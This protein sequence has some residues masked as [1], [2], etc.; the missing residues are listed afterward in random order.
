M[1][2]SETTRPSSRWKAFIRFPLTRIFLA[3]LIVGIPFILV[4]RV[5][6]LLPLGHTA[7]N[8]LKA[9]VCI[10]VACGM[11]R[12]AVRVLERRDATEFALKSAPVELGRG[13][14]TGALLF[15][16][17][18]G[19]LAVLGVYRVTGT[20]PWSSVIIPFAVA[21][22]IGTAE[23]IVF[24]GIIFRITEESLGTWIALLIS[25]MIFGLLHLIGPNST[26]LGA[27]SIVVGPSLLL[28]GAYKATG[29]LWFP[30]G[31]HVAWNFTQEG[32][33]G[34]M[35]SGHPAKGLLLGTLSGPEWLSG[36]TFGAE[37]SV[38]ATLLCF[39]A[40]LILFA[41]AI[42]K[43]CIVPPSWKRRQEA[44]PAPCLA[45]R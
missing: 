30:I 21:S 8:V 14:A 41:Q 15:A 16:A 1:N 32:I 34:V 39:F 2:P 31:L 3:G 13:L 22:V 6:P 44:D 4:Q 33:F 25:A 42:R 18:I 17:T 19:I 7:A 12:L 10:L 27:L 5:V 36:G 20:G 24:R 40:G 23:E 35:V 28:T 38:V 37:A 9:G 11:Y 45:P 43:K 26:I 29:R